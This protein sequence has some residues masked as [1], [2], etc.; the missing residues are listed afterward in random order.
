MKLN[1]VSFRRSRRY[2]VLRLLQPCRDEV[3]QIVKL[4]GA[5]RVAHITVRFEIDI[6]APALESLHGFLAPRIL[7]DGVELAVS[8]QH[9]CFCIKILLWNLVDEFLAHQE[10]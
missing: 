10:I 3:F 7:D 5:S 6:P 4:F 2:L 1:R 9:F 8:H